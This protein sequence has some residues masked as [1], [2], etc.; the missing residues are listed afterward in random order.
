LLLFLIW[1]AWRAEPGPREIVYLTDIALFFGLYLFLIG[2]LALWARLL[3]VRLPLVR[4]ERAM[5]YFNRVMFAARTFVPVWFGVGVFYL[6]WGR[7]VQNLLGVVSDWPVQ[8]PGA[9]I[10]VMPPI[11]AWAGLWWAQYPAD[12]ALRA[13]RL[14]VD[15]DNGAQL[16]RPPPLWSYLMQQLRLQVLF[17][18][19]P[20]LLILLLHD[21]VLLVLWRGFDM[22]V[23]RTAAEGFITFGSALAIFMVVPE[24]LVRVLPTQVLPRSALRDRMEAMCRAHRLKFRDILIWRTDNRIANALVM[25]VVP[26]FRY[27]LL[28]DLLLEEMNDEQVE[29]V[30]AHELGHVVHR[31]MIWYLVFL[32]VLILMLALVAVLL[33]LQLGHVRLPAWMPPELVTT[34]V[35]FTGF[36]IAFGYV[37]RRF[38]RQADVFAARTIERMFSGSGYFA[39]QANP[40]DPSTTFVAQGL[41]KVPSG[42]GGGENQLALQPKSQPKSHVGRFGASIFASALERVAVINNMPLGPRGRWEGGPLR[43]LAYVLE[44]MTDATNNWLHGSITQRMRALHGMSSDPS[45]THRFDRRMARLYVTLVVA[46]V[47]SGAIAWAIDAPL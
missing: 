3:A 30:F 42:A 47:L 2:M 32:K 36:V 24:V 5:R 11:L 46:L 10:G 19:I 43:R 23:E 35:G 20:I 28:S 44:C 17:T 27:V 21:V 33:D 4:L 22:R 9:I 1:M 18:A 34:L 25:G 8:L 29:A 16:Y 45:H 40:D 39:A 14:L 13:K 26:R 38:E 41:A 31:H 6:G 7:L 12:N 37:S 15:F